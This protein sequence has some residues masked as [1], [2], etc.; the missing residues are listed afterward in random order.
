MVIKDLFKKPTLSVITLILIVTCV[1]A[2]PPDGLSQQQST[3]LSS[4]V[5]GFTGSLHVLIHIMTP[6]IPG[7][8]MPKFTLD[9]SISDYIDYGGRG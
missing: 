5:S 8:R 1:V 3:P 9:H 6:L 2:S 7:L 4:H